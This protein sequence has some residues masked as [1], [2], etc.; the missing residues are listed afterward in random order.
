[1]RACCLARVGREPP[2]ADDVQTNPAVAIVRGIARARQGQAAPGVAFAGDF[3][4][5]DSAI[6]YI[7]GACEAALGMDQHLSPL[8]T[9]RDMTTWVRRVCA[10]LRSG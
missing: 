3:T 6:R 5:D 8:R 10:P 4:P 1:M 2:L 9:R 7:Q